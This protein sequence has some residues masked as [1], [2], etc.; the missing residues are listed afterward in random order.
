[1]R[2]PLPSE[3]G[4]TAV[5]VAPVSWAEERLGVWDC[6]WIMTNRPWLIA[7]CF[8]GT[9]LTTALLLVLIPSTYT[10]EVMLLIERRPPRVLEMHE[11]STGF[12]VPD[13]SGSY[14]TQYALLKSRALAAQVIRELG[15]T[16]QHL[17]GEGQGM[18]EE[19]K[20]HSR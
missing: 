5:L 10:A 13:D 8:G 6:W 14:K 18:L 4:E 15:L 11:A 2:L 17:R 20:R 7:L 12:F 9:V 3:Q 19:A 16:P 1:M